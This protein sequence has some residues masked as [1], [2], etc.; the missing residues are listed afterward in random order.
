[1][2][3][4]GGNSRMVLAV[5]IA[6]SWTWSAGA[7]PPRLYRQPAHQSPV[8]A[9]PDDLLILAGDGLGADDKVVYQASSPS[10]ATV[11]PS[12]APEE[13]TADLGVADI[14]NSAGIPLALTIRLPHEIVAGRAYRM[15]VRNPAG[16]WSESVEINDPR[17]LWIS[18]SIV[19]ASSATA[20][21]PRYLKVI[22]RNLQPRGSQPVRVRLSGARQYLL[23]KALNSTTDIALQTYAA[24]L[25]LPPSIIPGR[26][27]VD[28]SVDG[29]NWTAVPDSELTVRPDPP[30]SQEFR[31]SDPQFGGCRPDDGVDDTP[32]VRSAISAAAGNGGGAVV[33]EQGTWDVISNGIELPPG[34]QLMGKGR[35]A[36]RIVRHDGIS[37]WPRNATF[38]LLGDNTVKGLWFADERRF[39]ADDPPRPVL[40]L[41]RLY[42][43]DLDPAAVPATVRDVIITANKFDKT[44]G[45]IV[46]GGASIERLFVTFNQFGD[47]R[48]A[49]AIGGSRYNVKHRFR[50]VDSIVS[51]NSFM[52]GSYIDPGQAQGVIAS[53][54]GASQRLDFSGNDA[55]GAA[56]DYLNSPEDPPGWRAAF[57]FHMNDSHE[58]MLISENR[59]SCT[60]DK[61]GDGEAVALDNNANT[62]A[63]GAARMVSDATADSVRTPGPMK[64]EQDHRPVDPS[65]YYVGHWVH[66]AAGPGMGQARK[67]ISYTLNPRTA[68]IAFSVSPP[69]DV[70]PLPGVSTITIAREFWQ[71]YVVDNTI[72]QRRPLCQKSNRTRPKGG[73]ITVWAQTSDSVVEGNQQFDTDG[74]SFQQAY[75]AD[76]Q[77]CAECAA[78]ADLQSF[79][80][81]RGNR[82]DGEY[83]WD[84]ACS[85]SG[86]TASYAASPSPRSPPPLLST[87][88]SIS[89]NTILHADGLRGG[90]I[91]VLPTWYSGPSGYAKPLIQ[92]LLIHH[93]RIVNVDGAQSRNACNYE[94]AGRIG[95]RIQGS[96]SVEG[97]VLYMNDCENVSRPL[98]D[99]GSHTLALCDK[100]PMHSCECHDH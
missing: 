74:I 1:M 54:I 67:I 5:A 30:A 96:R 9:E 36:T 32:C 60:G 37:L 6:C 18:P 8:R 40:Q 79:L 3:A 28:L 94:S 53:E 72:D 71:V 84:S 69:W 31:V 25:R 65:T 95:I 10:N 100:S 56:R 17:P 52:P 58:M 13:N 45:A 59:T 86:I 57:F 24:A 29:Q 61:A 93:N 44:N 77:G 26:Y 20:S 47:Y 73:A 7:S 39:T 12:S 55:D 50:F 78:G 80:E 14:V 63:F 81:I 41:G 23:Q 27:R 21:L 97:T 11:R 38:V 76:E 15:W 98:A 89:H 90:A 66:V 70:P 75:G 85:I 34:I 22:G 49:L 92:N 42:S 83:D 43:T 87:G 33:L 62:F 99:G 16:E 82:I 68:E 91:T 48:L 46:G 4:V 19:R 35:D 64:L 51:R 2:A 88:V